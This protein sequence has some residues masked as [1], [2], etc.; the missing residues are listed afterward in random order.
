MAEPK[1][2]TRHEDWL[3]EAAA[4]PTVAPPRAG[5]GSSRRTS[6][7]D[8]GDMPK[9]PKHVL[10]QQIG[11]GGM[12]E[13]WTARHE[14]SGQAR[15]VKVLRSDKARSEDRLAELADRFRR[16]ANVLMALR[17][18]HT[19]RIHDWGQ[20]RDG[21]S[22]WLAMDLLEGLDLEKLVRD[23]GPLPHGRAIHLLRQ[24]C[25][26]LQEAH[27]KGLVHRDLKPANVFVCQR[28]TPDHVVVLDFGLAR[29][30]SASEPGGL[31]ASGVTVGTPCFM[32]PEQIACRR[33]LG[34]R[35]DLYS[36]GC[37]AHFLLT[38][39][40][41]LAGDGPVA[42]VLNH[43]HEPPPAPS[44]R[45]PS[46]P[47]ELDALVLRCLAKRPEDRPASAAEVAK[48]LERCSGTWTWQDAE[49]WWAAHPAPRHHVP[50]LADPLVDVLASFASLED[51]VDF[52]WRGVQPPEEGKALK[53]LVA[54]AKTLREAAEIAAP[55][56]RARNLL[57]RDLYD[58]LRRKVPSRLSEIDALAEGRGMPLPGRSAKPASGSSGP[59]D[60]PEAR[61]HLDRLLQWND[62]LARS[63]SD[64]HEVFL[65]HGPRGQ[66]LAD[67]AERV[68]R[69]LG[70]KLSEAGHDNFGPRTV[71]TEGSPH[72]PD[73]WQTRF[74]DALAV[75]QG[76]TAAAAI[77]EAARHEPVLVF[78]GKEPLAPPERTKDSHFD[79]LLVF[80]TDHLP[81]IVPD[82]RDTTD[83]HPVR[84]YLAMECEDDS[85]YLS[86]MVEALARLASGIG[87]S[88]SLDLAPRVHF[89]TLADIEAYLR[90]Y[91]REPS[92][93]WWAEL[94]TRHEHHRTRDQD[95]R[96]LCG[97]LDRL[98]QDHDEGYDP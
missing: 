21:G 1:D 10:F 94:R 13:V 82:I 14:K 77:E 83:I 37:I 35:A 59:P 38:G 66:H 4:A 97:A 6:S 86:R 73:I 72:L 76:L 78:F 19:V 46:I 34:H 7:P 70:A 74:A 79:A 85:P 20:L 96:K 45:V 92:E 2:T 54:P 22:L 61:L 5:V 28:P 29:K 32:A 53:P 30:V 62:L 65:I 51:L 27:D 49:G 75:A 16:E 69:Y 25:L 57:G 43:M 58:L 91:R 18:P 56:L 47:T 23:H 40:C 71:A 48:A 98:L 42:W 52:L 12:G 88:F 80:L 26:S 39:K 15:A 87:S 55:E 89:P 9:V 33:D 64:H 90:L 3:R 63:A 84:F 31:T 41:V 44:S 68:K 17:S 67:F 8:G 36:L 93:R 11:A 50:A 24:I 95:F 81:G 60:L